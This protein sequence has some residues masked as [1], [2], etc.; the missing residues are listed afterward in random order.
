MAK[1]KQYTGKKG[2]LSRIFKENPKYDVQNKELFW[3]GLGVAG[4]N[5]TYNLVSGWFE[6]FCNFVLFIK[7]MHTGV[8]LGVMRG[9]DAVNDPLA[10]AIIDARTPKSGDKLKPYLRI[11]AIP[12]GIMA[13][14]L[15]VNWGFSSYAAKI[16][17]VSS[18]YFVWDTFYSF[19]DTAQWGMVARISNLPERR[20]K[21]AYVGRIGGMFGGLIPGLIT[22]VVG[23]VLD[24]IIPITLTQL[25]ILLGVVFGFGGMLLTL[26]FSKI[27]ER[28]PNLP[29]E[30]KM[31]GGFRLLK[32][33]KIVIMIAIGS[34][35][36]VCVLNL[37]QI[38][39]FQTMVRVNIGGKVVNGATILL[40]FLIL[41]GLPGFFSIFFTP[42]FAK[43]F[44]GMKNLLVIS[45]VA[46]IVCRIIMF[47]VGYEGWRLIV[48]CAM[49]ALINF[50]S[51][52]CGIATTAL[53]SDS[54]DYTEWKTGQRNEGTVFS[55]QNFLSK[56]TGSISS[57][58]SGLTLTLLKFEPEKFVANPN[59]PLSA[60]FT[61]WAWPLYSLAPI[62]GSVMNLIPLLMLK[63]TPEDRARIH[64]ELEK[65]R[66]EKK[67]EKALVIGDFTY[68]ENNRFL[69]TEINIYG[70]DESVEKDRRFSSMLD[71]DFIILP[72]QEDDIEDK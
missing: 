16:A 27:N 68:G 60:E 65:R 39:F 72:P 43:K 2:L 14:L 52:M 47:F 33:N 70:R 40:P 51:N 24:G 21:A 23:L 1:T 59:A 62:A 57:F 28:V 45:S 63:Y 25:F 32:H 13:C 8:I 37:S 5:H 3:F 10:G 58:F 12:I 29:P 61:K 26:V 71:G 17:Y 34:I 4:Q 9:W 67:M 69:D 18:I 30:K 44:G 55:M 7:P 46:N 54:V 15:F 31:L 50:P 53:W 66:A 64:E 48:V 49:H 38:N 56:M 19:Q 36:N 11:F 41:S 42:Y 22:T 20:E 35:L 6:Y